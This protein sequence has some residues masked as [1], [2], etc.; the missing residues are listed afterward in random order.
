MTDIYF[1]QFWTR[2][3][4]REGRERERERER[5]SWKGPDHKGCECCV[6]EFEIDAKSSEELLKDSVREVWL[7]VSDVK[8]M[9][10]KSID[11]NLFGGLSFLKI[12]IQFGFE[13]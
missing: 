3:F 8:E 7:P 2:G 10:S 9:E 4:G 5:E 12:S 11:A 6:D 1:S 13:K